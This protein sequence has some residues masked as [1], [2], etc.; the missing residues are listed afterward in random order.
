MC[1]HAAVCHVY[2]IAMFLERDGDND[3]SRI[4]TY[5]RIRF[6]AFPSKSLSQRDDHMVAQ[7]ALFV[8]AISQLGCCRPMPTIG[9]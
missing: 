7:S 5:Q 3:R 6:L 8:S 4:L 9:R 2:Q 1:I